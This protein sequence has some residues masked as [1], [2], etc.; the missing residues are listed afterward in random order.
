MTC[1]KLSP[2]DSKILAFGVTSAVKLWSVE[3]EARICNS[4]HHQSGFV[5][6][7]CFPVADK[8]RARIF[9]TERGSLIR[10]CWDD[11]SG[12][13]SD[14]VD[15]PGLGQSVQM[16]AFSHCGSLFAEGAEIGLFSLSV[17]SRS[18]VS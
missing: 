5:R 4:H 17:A 10:T 1:L 16:S 3:Q 14:I 8:G 12:V 11:L 9:A 15:A 2:D 6:S 13:T 18:R 7:M